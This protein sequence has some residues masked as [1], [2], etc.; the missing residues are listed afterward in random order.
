VP[1][2]LY[3]WRDETLERASRAGPPQAQ[4]P[5]RGGPD[6]APLDELAKAEDGREGFIDT[7]L[8]IWADSAYHLA[9]PSSVNRAY[10][11]DQDTGRLAK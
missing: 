5:A 1:E 3:G 7:P 4:S 2:P 9:Q 10:L 6:L 11:L 8:L